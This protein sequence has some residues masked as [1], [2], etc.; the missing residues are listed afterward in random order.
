MS[1]RVTDRIA[2]RLSESLHN[3]AGRIRPGPSLA[4]AA[5]REARR[6]RRNRRIAVAVTA[7]LAVLAIAIPVGLVSTGGATKQDIAPIDTPRPDAEPGK[8]TR[9]DLDVA[10]LPRGDAAEVPYYSKADVAIHD[11]DR[12]ISLEH[13]TVQ[14]EDAQVPIGED[15]GDVAFAPVA[16]GYVVTAHCCE[17]STVVHTATWLLDPDGNVRAELPGDL[18]PAVSA[19][20]R[21]LAQS[22]PDVDQPD[23][24][25][26]AT[27]DAT[28]GD[29]VD[30]A[31]PIT[32]DGPMVQGFVGDDV[33]IADTFDRTNPR[34]W[35]PATGGL[36]DVGEL[37][38]V[39]ATDGERL[40]LGR[41]DGCLV[42]Y[43]VI[44][45]SRL[46]S[47]CGLK[48]GSISTDGQYAYSD[49]GSSGPSAVVRASD[50]QPL[51]DIRGLRSAMPLTTEADGVL[52]LA[53]TQDERQAL[54]RCTFDGSC[55]RTSELRN[56]LPGMSTFTLPVRR[57]PS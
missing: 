57:G 28:T 24:R 5:Q 1:N 43:D 32:T 50:G 53:S 15:G 46:W 52:F 25:Y 6:I 49:L 10:A 31:E 14:M 36:T 7:C 12:A 42:A 35:D 38:K 3:Q 21:T 33:L 23:R 37:R 4:D 40:I 41:A 26:L 30:R 19:D 9:V 2:D 56:G 55:E 17:G 13:L 45:G 16:D 22:V 51:L 34:L 18:L 39:L 47:D 27:F 44:D 20:G 11:G 48:V 8:P 54:V 29:E